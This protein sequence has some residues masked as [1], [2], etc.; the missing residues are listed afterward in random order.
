M[1]ILKDIVDRI[2]QRDLDKALELCELSENSNN[3][4][5]I[6]N[7]KGVIYLLKNNLDLA[8]SNFLNSIKINEKFE[9]PIKNLY[10]IYLKKIIIKIF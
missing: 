8:E 3:K 6:S 4:H 1:S 10:S 9:D 7:F 5:I 2:K